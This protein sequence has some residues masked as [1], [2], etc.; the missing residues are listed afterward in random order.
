MAQRSDSEGRS[1]LPPDSTEGPEG[2]PEA[3]RIQA[4]QEVRAWTRILPLF[5]VEWLAL[6]YGERLRV[7]AR[8][9]VEGP[10]GVFFVVGK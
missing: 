8:Q 9:V 1:D 4:G 10:R 6:R 5:I 2:S 3:G 7:T